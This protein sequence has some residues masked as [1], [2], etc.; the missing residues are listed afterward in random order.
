MKVVHYDFYNDF[1][2]HFT[3][4]NEFEYIQSQKKKKRTSIP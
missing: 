3:D 4:M 1:G 2:G